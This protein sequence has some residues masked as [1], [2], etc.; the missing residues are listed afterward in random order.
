MLIPSNPLQ[1]PQ[2]FEAT[3]RIDASSGSKQFQ[4]VWLERDD[5]ERWVIDYRPRDCWRPLEDQRVH[6][7]G[8]T[9]TPRGQSISATHFE[10]ELLRLITPRPEARLVA[11]GAKRTL[12]GSLQRETGMVG[13]KSEGSSWTVFQ[14]HEGARWALYN[15]SAVGTRTGPMTLIG[16]MVELSPYSTHRAGPQLW[17]LR[18]QPAS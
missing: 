18:A 5:G 16:R 6:A 9:Y 4:G 17:V 13:S 2:T 11:V 12:T 10:V 8:H 14:T 7:T 1:T 3:L 15:P